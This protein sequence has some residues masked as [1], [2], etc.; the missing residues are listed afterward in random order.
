M[1]ATTEAAASSPGRRRAVRLGWTKVGDE[2]RGWLVADL[3]APGGPARW[4]RPA[5]VT[6]AIVVLVI[7]AVAPGWPWSML[8]AVI[9][10]SL[11]SLALA[12]R[13]HVWW[14]RRRRVLL[15]RHGLDEDG[16]P[17]GRPSLAGRLSPGPF[18]A[19]QVGV[20]L[21]A[22]AVVRAIGMWTRP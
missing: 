2:H 13:P 14:S 21:A 1:G 8:G 3:D 11:V 6:S 18:A 16:T 5:T 4:T 19:F 9:G 7:W 12:L 20:L 15:R 22:M 17:A 10:V